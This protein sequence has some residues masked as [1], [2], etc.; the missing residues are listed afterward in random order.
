MKLG[1]AAIHYDCTTLLSL[2]ISHISTFCEKPRK[3][4]VIFTKGVAEPIADAMAPA[5]WFNLF[6]RPSE[7]K[8]LG[9]GRG[10]FRNPS[11]I[12]QTLRSL[13]FQITA[14]L[15]LALQHVRSK[16][17]MQHVASGHPLFPKSRTNKFA[18]VVKPEHHSNN[19]HQT[20]KNKNRTLYL[21]MFQGCFS[22]GGYS[23]P[24]SI[25]T[26]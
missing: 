19:Q 10:V 6:E 16:M 24:I 9:L 20:N 23:E 11:A 1:S 8:G 13:L 3:S 25:D 14:V 7:L 21:R 15:L 2:S 5:L 18:L 4:G 17:Q 22:A 12:N 26:I